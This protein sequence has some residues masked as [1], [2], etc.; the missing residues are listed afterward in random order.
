MVRREP[1]RDDVTIAAAADA[2]DARIRILY[3]WKFSLENMISEFEKTTLMKR[4]AEGTL[5]DSSCA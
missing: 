4:L 3:I 2:A 5:T 1:G